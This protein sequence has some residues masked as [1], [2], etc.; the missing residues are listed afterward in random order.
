MPGFETIGIFHPVRTP[1]EFK[2]IR[3]D[4][5]GVGGVTYFGFGPIGASEGQDV[6][7]IKKMVEV[8]ALISITWADGN[9]EFDNVWTNRASL[10][11]A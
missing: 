7:Q 11:Y 1:G 5:T 2:A 10:A 6:W 3:I 8:G 4:E 9:A